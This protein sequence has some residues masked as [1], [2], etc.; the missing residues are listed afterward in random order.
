MNPEKQNTSE[1]KEPDTISD[2]DRTEP[3]VPPS[4]RNIDVQVEFGALSHQGKVRTN[5]EDSYLAVKL[6]RLLTPVLTNVP[7]KYLPVPFEESGYGM[8]VADGMGG[9]AAGEVASRTAIQVLMNLTTKAPKWTLKLDDEEARELMAQGI[10]FYKKID[11]KLSERAKTEPSLSG[12]GTT[13]TGT[14]SVGKNLFIVHVGDSRAY[15]FRDEKLY[16]MTRDQTVAQALADTGQISENDISKHPLRHIL[17]NAMGSHDGDIVAEIQQLKLAD[18]DRILLCSDGLTEMVS[19]E[20]IADVLTRIPAS[21]DACQA[22]VE[23]ALENGGKDNVTVVIARY[24]VT[25]T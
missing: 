19:D 6:S 20:A 16:Q 11:Y 3:S 17:T 4:K 14:Y 13:M 15:L 8:V 1:Y 2:L 25:T 10:N 21:A 12:M 18:G 23:L 24:S 7:D 22:L 5:N 9:Q